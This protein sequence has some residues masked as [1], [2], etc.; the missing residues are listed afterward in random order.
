MK[1]LLTLLFLFASF[2]VR[3]LRWLAVLQQKEYRFD[4]LFLFLR[5]NEGLKELIRIVPKK[6]DFSRT[7]LKRPKMTARSLLMLILFIIFTVIYFNIFGNLG[8]NYLLKFYPYP[9]WYDFA[10]FVVLAIIYLVFIPAFVMFSAFPT[11]I[12]SYAQTYKRLAQAKKILEISKP[13]VVGI[14]GSYGKTSTKILLNHVLGKK[15]TVFKTPKSYNTKYS[16]AN[17]IVKGYKG[18]EIAL[19]EYAAYKKGE[20][21]ELT[22]WIKPNM[23]VITGLTKQH[24]GLFGSLDDIIKAKSELVAGLSKNSTVVCNCYDEKTKEI[25]ETGKLISGAKLIS[26][27][28]SSGSIKISNP[29]INPEAK[30]QFRWGD[31]LV[32]TQL[33]GVQYIEVVHLVIATSLQFNMKKSEIIQALE[34]FN[35]H[36]NFIVTFI[37]PNRAFVVDD[38]DTSNPKGFE[39]MINL[40]KSF[41]ATRKVLVTPGI[42]DLGKD[43][44]EIHS[45]LAQKTKKVFDTVIYV[46]ESGQGDFRQFWGDELLT[47]S[48]QL[49]EVISSLDEND[50]VVIEGRMPAWAK[51]YLK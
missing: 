51:Q 2:F 49:Q 37:L 40:A 35:P 4:R 10:L 21:K 31:T 46:G 48:S 14:T 44:S 5:S 42:V 33:V 22:K 50:L 26:L 45:V 1:T 6:N 41:K 9:L 30:L 12:I 27:K 15:F 3:S 24:V 36:D 20:I 32:K 47:T 25:Y 38:G 16:V 19:I 23:A 18:Q 39:A 11:S 29:S 43:S 8:S 7:G 34:S 13:T 17:S 28:P